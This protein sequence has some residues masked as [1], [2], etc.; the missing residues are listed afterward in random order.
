MKKDVKLM[1]KQGKNNALILYQVLMKYSD[2]EHPLSMSDIKDYMAEETAECG[3]DSIAR[4]LDQLEEEMG[5]DIHRGKGQAARYYIDRRLLD[6]EELKLITDAVY[7][8]NFIEKG[9]ADNMIKKLKTLRSIYDGEELDRSIQCVNVAKAEND[10]IL[11]NVRIIQEAIKKNKQIIFDYMKWNNHKQLVR[12]NIEGKYSINPWTL[13]WANDRYYLY[14]Y[15]TFEKDG[16]RKERHYRVDKLDNIEIMET[17]RQGKELFMHFNADTYV[18]KRMGMYT[19]QE[20]RIKVR[21]PESLVGTFI[22]QFGK[23]IDIKEEA[24]CQQDIESADNEH[25]EKAEEKK[26][27]VTFCAVKSNVLLGWLI[28]LGNVEVLEPEDVKEKMMALLDK[29]KDYYK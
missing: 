18:A 20:R 17:D 22:D 28:G 19:D 1:G 12:K 9:I 15:D 7:A 26:L 25:N 16:V 29:N 4:Y 2:K 27:V 21:I 23:W 3:R 6:K 14:G 13:I 10:R 5:I 24:I 8:S 11:E